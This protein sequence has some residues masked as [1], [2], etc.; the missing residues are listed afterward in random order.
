MAASLFLRYSLLQ[1]YITCV[2]V[3]NISFGEYRDALLNTE[4]P[5]CTVPYSW[6]LRNP[7]YS[8]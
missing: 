7:K 6:L 3:N 1:V 4:L 2:Y 5:C 8:G